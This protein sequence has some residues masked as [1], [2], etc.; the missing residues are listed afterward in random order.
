MQLHTTGAPQGARQAQHCSLLLQVSPAALAP[1]K[2]CAMAPGRHNSPFCNCAKE[3]WAISKT[4]LSAASSCA[5]MRQLS[6]PMIVPRNSYSIHSGGSGCCSCCMAA[7][8]TRRLMAPRSGGGA[9]QK[10]RQTGSCW[11]APFKEITTQR[12]EGA[13]LRGVPLHC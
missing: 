13:A 12:V 4:S 10:K 6:R 5:H 1:R 11:P 7:W 3:H 2:G 9:S 8:D